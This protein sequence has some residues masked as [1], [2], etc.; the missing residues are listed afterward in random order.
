MAKNKISRGK[1]LSYS[2]MAGAASVIGV[3]AIL[4]SCKDGGTK[5]GGASDTGYQPLVSGMPEVTDYTDV[6]KRGKAF[7]GRDIKAGIIGCGSRGGGAA[8]NFLN[9][10]DG[11][12][13]V[14]MA[15][16][17]EDRLDDLRKNLAKRNNIVADDQ[18]Y[19][20]FDA[21]QK[22]IDNADIDM[23]IITTP[24]LFHPLHTKYAVEKGKHVFVEK[25]AAID[26]VGCRTMLAACKIA[27][28]KGLSI[29]TGTQRHH[30]AS[31]YESYKRV[32]EG[33][34]GE[35]VSGNV[36]WNQGGPWFIKRKAGWSDMEYMLRDFFSWSW[37][38]GDHIV[39]QCVHNVDIFTWFSQ[40][41][42]VSAVGMGGRA[43]RTTGDVYDFMSVDIVYEGG[44]HCHAMQ[45]QIDD[46]A[47]FTGEIIHGTKGTWNNSE[48][49]IRN[50]KGE[51]VWDW[52]TD[53]I[54]AEYAENCEDGYML[55]HADLVS[56]IRKDDPI[57]M[58]ELTVYSS[59]ACDMGRESAYHGPEYTF[60]EFINSDLDYM[61]NP[62]TMGS[63]PGGMPQPK[64][65]GKSNG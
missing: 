25:P 12:S 28:A 62:L 6:L 18:I 40:L 35:I 32:R 17:F 30:E 43:R 64:L 5:A 33:M 65:P 38:C 59:A 48:K 50:L 13:I 56:R 9:C 19:Y 51:V 61:P 10:G 7:D 29:V 42:P 58:A 54:K 49:K 47:N 24:T 3:P 57:V 22:L 34:I 45:R 16:I 37:L 36:Y 53:P 23:V 4:S 41:K 60:E 11:V 8:D 63:Y 46:C 44:V 20:G 55:E 2:A 27:R 1:F 21:Y 39:D 15:D 52:N 26:A 31:Y 14:A